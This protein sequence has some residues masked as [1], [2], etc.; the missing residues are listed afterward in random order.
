VKDMLQVTCEAPGVTLKAAP[1]S[2]ASSPLLLGAASTPIEVK[3]RWDASRGR[4]RVAGRRNVW[5][6]KRP[7]RDSKPERTSALRALSWWIAP[8]SAYQ[9]RGANCPSTCGATK[10][11]ERG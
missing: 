2:S 7:L 1:R 4:G 11:R 9:E 8:R 5:P 3:N 6:G 10:P